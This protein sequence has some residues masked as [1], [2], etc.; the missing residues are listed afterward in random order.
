LRKLILVA[1]LLAAASPIAAQPPR[2]SVPLPPPG[3]VGQM[4]DRVADVADDFMDVDFGPVVDAVEPGRPHYERTLGDYAA[5]RDP[6][7]R[8]RLHDSIALTSAR[9]DAT[10][11]ELAAMAPLMLRSF[12]QA[13][14]RL[15]AAMD[16]PPPPRGDYRDPADRFDQG[17]A[18]PPPAGY[19]QEGPSDQPN[20]G[21]Y[22]GPR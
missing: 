9:I 3:A 4:G 8:E 22:H 20:D 16:A 13:R 7:A 11:R 18:P 21:F 17:F 19:T 1:G 14:R 10:A 6:Y 15:R 2:Y 12:E 5:R